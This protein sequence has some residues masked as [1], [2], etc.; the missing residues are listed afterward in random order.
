MHGH[1]MLTDIT[2]QGHTEQDMFGEEFD[3]E[4]MQDEETIASSS[5]CA[6]TADSCDDKDGFHVFRA[7]ELIAGRYLVCFAW[8]WVLHRTYAQVGVTASAQ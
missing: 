2:I 8:V 1:Y 3:A 5:M 7:G 6:S 4:E